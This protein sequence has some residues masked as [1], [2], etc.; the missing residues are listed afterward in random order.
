VVR[1]LAGPRW[2]DDVWLDEA[3]ATCLSYAALA[4]IAG[5][6]ESLSWAGFAY[7]GKPR[8]YEADELPGRQPVSSP[9]STAGRAVGLSGQPSAASSDSSTG[10]AARR[11]SVRPDVRAG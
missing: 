2:R 3:I 7:T 11:C 9:V 6:S 4:A 8:A 1:L 10:R 5:V